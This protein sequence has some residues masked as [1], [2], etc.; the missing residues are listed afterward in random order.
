MNKLAKVT[1]KTPNYSV[2]IDNK[3]F[4]D[5]RAIRSLIALMDAHAVNGGAACHWGGPA[6]M[7]ECWSAIH[8]ALFKNESWF[9]D[10]NFVNDMGHA[11]NGLYAIKALYNFADISFD[12]L[13]TFRAFE[14]K[15]TGHGES[16][17]FPEGVLLSN[18]P[19]GSA[20]PQAQGLAMADKLSK[21]N[22]K[23]IVTISDGAC[24]EGEAK[25]SMS[26]IPGL[27][28]SKKINPFILVISDNN[29][30][31]SGR[32]TDAFSM[33]PTFES[34]EKLGWEVIDEKNG[35]DLEACYKSF[36][37]ALTLC[38]KKP[39]CIRLKTIKGYGIKE[40]E[41]NA[42]GGHGF[43]LKAYDS[44]ITAFIDE[45]WNNQAPE[46]FK[47]WAQLLTKK[48]G[49][50]K[51]ENLPKEKVQ[52]GVAKALI[53]L[54]EAGS[55]IVSLSSDLDGSTGVKPFRTKFPESSFDL[56]IAESNMVSAAAGFS[57]SGYTPIVDTFAAFGVT[58]GNLPLIMASLS[59]CPVIAFF[60][61]T[62]FQ[63]A[64]DGASHQSLTYFSALASIPNVE[65]IALSNSEEA[66]ELVT[67]KIKEYEK[68][69]EQSKAKS[70]IF[71]LGRETFEKTTKGIDAIASNEDRLLVQGS[72]LLISAS[73]PLVYEALKAAKELKKQN[74]NVGVIN[75]RFLNSNNIKKYGELLKSHSNKLI[76]LEDHQLKSGIGAF[77]T[78][79]LVSSGINDFK[80]KSLAV[81]GEFGQSAY[82]ASELYNKYKIDAKAVIEAVKTMV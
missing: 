19:L 78:H 73:G 53:D 69:K 18:G 1:N 9:D 42:S 7:A 57:K 33:N 35:N 40:T 6:A 82:K 39:V 23:T 5:P 47:N 76:T 59:N 8:E 77:L 64:A 3:K 24:M 61:H 63:D 62:G 4:A 34:L 26:A 11:E 12:T 43:P 38:E 32:M 2:E 67:F 44:K 22:R 52:V 46:E 65:L 74:I 14:S 80:L 28:E 66:Y 45:L 48:P 54:K 60:S 29:T 79:Q 72:D 16:H 36:S 49:T 58:K 37:K 10:Y 30:K 55:K 50:E 56:G 68:L 71:F 75:R 20:L 15:L 27:H 25:E 17:L 81:N 51:K 21:N 31:L 41:E 70:L 13:K